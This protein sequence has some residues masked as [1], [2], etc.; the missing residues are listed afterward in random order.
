[1]EQ[2]KA[3]RIPGG[4]DALLPKKKALLPNEDAL[5]PGEDAL[6]PGVA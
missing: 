2:P 5:I 4:R 3:S 6:A 1:M